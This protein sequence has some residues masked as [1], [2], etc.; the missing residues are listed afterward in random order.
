L[1]LIA[2][3]IVA[4]AQKVGLEPFEAAGGNMTQ[5]P[6]YLALRPIAIRRGRGKLLLTD[7]RRGTGATSR[8]RSSA[9]SSRTLARRVVGRVVDVDTKL[10]TPILSTL[11]GI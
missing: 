4:N 11:L 8:G 10:G 2:T 5:L 9:T 6:T 3:A 1:L 7:R